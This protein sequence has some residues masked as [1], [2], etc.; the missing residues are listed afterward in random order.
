MLPKLQF[1]LTNWIDGMKISRDHFLDS[2][3][4][5]VDQLRDTRAAA[6]TSV[7]YGLLKP[8]N[9][10]KSALDCNTSTNQSGKFKVTVSYC[11]AVTAGGCRIEIIPGIHPELVSDNDSF[12]ANNGGQGSG[13]YAMISVDPYNREPFGPAS[14]E[15]YP[16]RNKYSVSAYKLSLIPMD[17]VDT[18]SMGANHLAVA[19]F[20]VR[21]GELV[22][23]AEYIPPCATIAA[24]PG[25]KQIY[26]TVAERLNQIQEASA[27]IVRKV[28]EGNQ[29]TPLAQNVRKVCE[30][31]ISH[32]ASEFFMFRMLYRQQS[33]IYMANTV[34]Q[35]AA[36]INVS[37]SLLP[38]K[39]KE[40]LTQ[41][42]SYWNEVS[43]GKF[44]ELLG[45]VTNADYD[46]E[47]IYNFYQPLLAF[48]KLWAELLD[49]LKE[50]KLIGQRNEKFDFGGRTMESPKEKGKG[51]FSIFD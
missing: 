17:D 25:T 15:E 8:M 23:D 7:D 47:D 11:R 22:R 32:I 42:F 37:L 18:G 20:I 6:M 24:H 10:E 48:L 50:L 44:E 45:N 29:N 21:N 9:G 33:P 38:V 14:A 35:L 19:R 51:K 26:N 2:E 41:Y 49:K 3:N 36:L 31:G 27:E 16:P 4:A 30:Q 1:N 40:E 43:P 34:V 46:H 12:Y 13:Y 28:Y 5:I 39:E